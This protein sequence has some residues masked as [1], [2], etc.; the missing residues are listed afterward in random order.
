[1]GTKSKYTPGLLKKIEEL[2][3]IGYPQVMI[4]EALG[5]PKNS[6]T[7][8][9]YNYRGEDKRYSKFKAFKDCLTRARAKYIQFH[10]KNIENHAKDDWRASK[11]K[12]EINSPEHFSERRRLE[13]SGKE[14]GPV[15]IEVVHYGK[16]KGKNGK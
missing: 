11:Y 8:Q 16:R 13:L 3:S 12:L 1:M 7:K 6:I 10:L 2:A 15:V 14:G 4:E 5:L 9:K